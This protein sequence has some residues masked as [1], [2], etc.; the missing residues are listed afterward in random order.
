MNLTTHQRAGHV[1]RCAVELMEHTERATGWTWPLQRR[2]QKQKHHQRK[3]KEEK[4]EKKRPF[5]D[6]PD[7]WTVDR[8]AHQ[9]LHLSSRGHQSGSRGKSGEASSS[10]KKKEKKSTRTPDTPN[11]ITADRA[12]TF[13]IFQPIKR[14]KRGRTI[15]MS[16]WM[17][18]GHVFVGLSKEIISKN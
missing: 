5:P 12:I 7:E 14:T 1:L 17:D 18:R 2:Q 9:G 6:G 13:V 10:I 8:C 16:R 4:K 11:R 3:K 15:R